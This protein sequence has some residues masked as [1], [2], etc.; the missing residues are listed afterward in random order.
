M[1]KEEKLIAALNEALK[2]WDD[3]PSLYDDEVLLDALKVIRK[4][5]KA[6]NEYN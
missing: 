4:V 6:L 3:S 5:R 1:N 2:T